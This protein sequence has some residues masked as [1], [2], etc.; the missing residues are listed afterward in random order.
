MATITD[1]SATTITRTTV[2]TPTETPSGSSD[3]ATEGVAKIYPSIYSKVAATSS[4][5]DSSTSSG[6]K[7][8]LTKGELGGIIGGAVALLLIVLAV[9]FFIIKRLAKTERAVQ[10]RRETTSGSGTRQT[11]EKSATQVNIVRVQPT[12]SEVDAMDY[13]PLMMSS[14]LASPRRFHQQSQHVNGRSRSDSDV[15]SQPS[16]YSTTAPRWNTPSVGSDGGESNAQGYFEQPPRVHGNPAGRPP[17]RASQ[18]SS[19]Y[20]YRPAYEQHARQYSNASELSAGSDSDIRSQHGIGSPLIP[21]TAIELG[22]DGGFVPE[23]PGSDTETESNGAHGASDHRPPRQPRK[24]SMGFTWSN[25]AAPTSTTVN[26]PPSTQANTGRRRG[27]SAVGPLDGQN[28]SGG[29]QRNE[30][31]VLPEKRL[32]SID[33][34]AT[35]A[36]PAAAPTPKSM[37]GYFGS[38][39]TA[40]GQTATGPM[41]RTDLIPP[42]KPGTDQIGNSGEQPTANHNVDET[43]QR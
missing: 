28:G 15:P 41:S 19:Q 24:R 10:S 39:I 23:L 37:H 17:L 22:I 13:D 16:G 5:D 3:G 31:T 8:G 25:F 9:S 4:D 12:P 36:A 26:K 38:L 42:T 43:Q 2:I 11:N 29:R 27:S 40:V 20:S 6:S 18:G 30:D 1:G 14:S 35:A 7:G 33:E 32:G 21:P 34:S